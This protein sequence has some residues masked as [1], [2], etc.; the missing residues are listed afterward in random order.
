MCFSVPGKG[1]NANGSQ[2]DRFYHA[3]DIYYN[4]MVRDLAA[5]SEP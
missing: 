2:P 3:L 5:V 1:T 4:D